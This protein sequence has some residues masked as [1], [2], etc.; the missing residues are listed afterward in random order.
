VNKKKKFR[1][2]TV[3]R[4]ARLEEEA[5][6]R[7][8]A[9]AKRESEAAQAERD[10]REAAYAE[11]AEIDGPTDGAL[12]EQQTMT[13]SLRAE[14]LHVANVN[15]IDA[16]DRLELAREDL[17]ARARR[18][19]T[20]ED[21]EERHNISFAITAALAAQRSLDDMVRYRRKH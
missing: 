16:R 6:Q 19:K 1:L 8:T 12:F 3:L 18:T 21:L 13:N 17:M 15:N 11:R 20:L 4:V 2:A 14:A 7:R 10:A 9:A 5:E